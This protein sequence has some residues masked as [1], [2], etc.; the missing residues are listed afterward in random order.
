MKGIEA[1][2]QI[3]W[4]RL[5]G[6]AHLRG[7]NYQP[8]WGKNG[9]EIWW[10]FDAARYRS[11]LE[12]GIELFPG[13]N[14]VRIWLSISAWRLDPKKIA[15]HM[16]KAIRISADLDLLVI[17]CLFTRWRGIPEFDPISYTD[18]ANL[19]FSKTFSPFLDAALAPQKSNPHVLAWDLCN[20]AVQAEC[21]Q[22]GWGEEHLDI[23]RLLAVQ[24]TWLS[25]IRDRVDALDPGAKT[26]LGHMRFWHSDAIRKQFESMVDL[27]TFHPYAW[28][29]WHIDGRTSPRDE[30]FDQRIFLEIEELRKRKA[31]KPLVAGEC[32][33]GSL[34]D[35]ER[36]EEI[37]ISLGV[38]KK[39][40]IG[41]LP[42]A[43]WCSPVADL[44][45][46]ELGPVSGPGYMGFIQADGSLR[47]HHGIYNQF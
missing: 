13:M 46:P 21:H 1:L 27:L 6:A 41:F 18:F 24:G 20:E 2:R 32:C 40:G 36:G 10:N 47:P 35:V 30:H 34:D 5:D 31:E 12:R 17:P 25:R 26:C 3:S 38:F 11:E 42:H 28:L 33:W 44:H 9:V 8:T 29:D 22:K 19:D 7:F 4:K 43:L 15:K 37:S 23:D 39:H 45:P 16:E 14:C